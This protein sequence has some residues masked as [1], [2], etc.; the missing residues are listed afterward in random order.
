VVEPGGTENFPKDYAEMESFF[1]GLMRI[2]GMNH[3]HSS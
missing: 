1:N 3:A 2:I